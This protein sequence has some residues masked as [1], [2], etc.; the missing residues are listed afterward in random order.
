MVVVVEGYVEK[1]V[2][3]LKKALLNHCFSWGVR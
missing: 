2:F 3:S 1:F